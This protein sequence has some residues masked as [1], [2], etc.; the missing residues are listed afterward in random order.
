M[1]IQIIDGFQVNTALPID[2]RIV[3][4]GSAARN[5][6]PFKYEGLRVFDTSNGIPY[7]WLNGGWVSENASGVLGSGTAEYIP[8]YTSSN[9]ISNSLLYQY[10]GIIKT[11]DTGNGSDLV[12][13]DPEYGTVY[14]QAG[15]YGPGSNIT[16]I[17]GSNIN[18][19]SIPVSGASSKLINGST[20]QVLVSGV[21][22]P[23][24]ANQ[25]LLSVGTASSSL[26]SNITRVPTGSGTHYLTFIGSGA[27]SAGSGLGAGVG[28]EVIRSSNVD[29][30]Y[31]P[32]ARTLS[33]GTVSS[34]RLISSST[35]VSSSTIT[36]GGDINAGAGLSTGN[37][38]ITLGGLYGQGL[39]MIS[40]SATT[41]ELVRNGANPIHFRNGTTA[42]NRLTINGSGSVTI[43]NLGTGP[44]YSS[45]GALTS[46]NP[47][48]FYLKKNIEP[49]KYG[50][51]EILQLNAVSFD[52][53]EDP[54]NQGKQFGFIAQEVQ[55]I[56]PEFV[57]SGEYLGLDKDAI[58]TVLIKA[59]QE[60]Q[61]Q[62]EELKSQVESLINKN[63]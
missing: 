49:I 20:G 42:A 5:A 16:Q 10:N 50:L 45:G 28:N 13:I 15:F 31:V 48:D 38:I 56:I 40:T 2:N 43:H 27:W 60:Q 6:I 62:I 37:G 61:A 34:T 22:N 63:I 7:A 21:T 9:V 1:S 24:W 44:V 30:A 17:N 11:A 39:A 55:E 26:N 29:L 35:I 53:K 8:L 32:G 46:T 58:F 59:F 33:V 54:I 12:E 14:A 25:S 47:S 52:W 18:N 57:K 36:G 23:S 4:S 3:A 41:L 19:G 51:K